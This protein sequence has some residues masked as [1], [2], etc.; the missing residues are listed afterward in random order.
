MRDYMILLLSM[1]WLPL[2]LSAQMDSRDSAASGHR[3]FLEY[4]GLNYGCF[5]DT[6]KD[7]PADTLL[8]YW[9][10]S[11]DKI[12][13]VR[14]YAQLMN[15]LQC[16]LQSNSQTIIVNIPSADLF[17]FRKGTPV[18]YS[19]VVVGKPSTPTHTVSSSIRNIV[20][21]PYWMVPRSIATKELLPKIKKDQAFLE[22][23]NF[24]V[25]DNGGKIV[26]PA[27]VP[28]SS[29]SKTFF[30]YQLRQSTGCDN[31]L[32]ILKF[33]F[34]NPFSAYLHDTP[35]KHLFSRESRFYSHGCIRVERAIELARLLLGENVIAVDTLLNNPCR[36]NEYPQYVP[37]S[38][39]VNLFIVYCL[40][41]PTEKGDLHFFRNVYRKPQ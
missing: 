1:T 5:T 10:D 19:K 20:L 17:V 24:Q 39:P 3:S 33:D 37:L 32:G 14:R 7:R 8:A 2:H 13:H 40:A 6:P 26:D 11:L 25:L 23:N 4:N 16:A 36:L 22:N 9:E 34:Y 35:E 29:L 28:W 18:F 30:P 12:P 21:Y 31:S 27:K 38:A 41:W 15:W